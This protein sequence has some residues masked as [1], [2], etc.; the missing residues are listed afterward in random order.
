M[1][2]HVLA[3]VLRISDYLHGFIAADIL[4][5]S[6]SSA[7]TW[8]SLSSWSGTGE[9]EHMGQKSNLQ[10]ILSCGT[11]SISPERCIYLKLRERTFSLHWFLS[12]NLAV[13][14]NRCSCNPSPRDTWILGRGWRGSLKP[15]CSSTSCMLFPLKTIDWKS[16]PKRQL[17][18]QSTLIKF[19]PHMELV[20]QTLPASGNSRDSSFF[21]LFF[22]ILPSMYSSPIGPVPAAALAVPSPC[23][24]LLR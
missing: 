12:G 1:S 11:V 24:M 19:C 18:W 23:A 6:Y 3:N 9:R 8:P 14:C 5:L 10:N 22:L 13:Q 17:A 2:C 4:F 20:S 16:C 7:P 15:S 21:L